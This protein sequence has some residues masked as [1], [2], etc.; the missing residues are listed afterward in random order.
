MPYWPGPAAADQFLQ[1]EHGGDPA[2]LAV[3]VVDGAHGAGQSRRRIWSRR[4]RPCPMAEPSRPATTVP[5]P[6][7]ARPAARRAT[8]APWLPASSPQ[9]TAGD[10][11]RGVGGADVLD[12]RR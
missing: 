2:G 5:A 7:G 8:V 10:D 4:R 9:S 6:C 3:D 1:C 12:C 11:Q